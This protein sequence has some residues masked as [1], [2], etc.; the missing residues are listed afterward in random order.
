MLIS[1]VVNGIV[2]P[3]VLIFMLILVNSR[4][5]MGTHKNGRVYNILCWITVAVLVV[6][7]GAYILSFIG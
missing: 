7:T 1:Q 4:K 3:V 5:L 6:L 2:L